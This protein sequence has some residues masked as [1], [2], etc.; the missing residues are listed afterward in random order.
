MVNIFFKRKFTIRYDLI[1]LKYIVFF[2][3]KFDVETIFMCV[4]PF[5]Q[6]HT[7]GY[8][9][10]K[11]GKFLKGKDLKEYSL[12][13]VTERK[14]EC[15]EEKFIDYVTTEQGFRPMFNIKRGRSCGSKEE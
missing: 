1:V 2:F 7:G 15:L 6:A 9:Q 4:N 14:A 8:D 11:I 10:Q 5:F 3:D 12:S 13:W